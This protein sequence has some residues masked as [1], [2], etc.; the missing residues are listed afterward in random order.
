LLPRSRMT[1]MI[2][3]TPSLISTKIYAPRL[4]PGLVS[5]PHL[6]ERLKAGLHCPLTLISAPAG[7]GK[8][9][10]IAGLA[11]DVD[12]P[13]AWLSLDEGDNDPIRFWAYFIS[14]LQTKLPRAGNT[15]IQTLKSPEVPD[16]QSCLTQLI[17]EIAS[18]E[19][20]FQPYIHILDD[21]HLIEEETI[22]KDLSFLIEH[23]P[24]QLRIVIS[25]RADPPLPLAR[26]RARGQLSEFRAKDLRF[27][28]KE[29]DALL[30]GTMGLGLSDKEVVAVDARTEGWIASL[31]MVGISIQKHENIPGFITAFTGTHRHV[32]DYLTEEVLNRQTADTRSFLLETSILDRVTGPLC[33][34]VTGRQDGQEMMERL[35]SANLF[36]VSL[37][38]E[39]KWYRYH[40][41]FSSMLRSRLQQST[42]ERVNE[43][44]KRAAIWFQ[45][46]GL[47]EEAISQ[48]LAT[49]D[50]ELSS[51]LIEKAAPAALVLAEIG[52][53]LNWLAKLPEATVQR[54]PGLC[55][56]YAFVLT[57]VGRV[58][59]AEAW[60]R[61]IEGLELAG[62]LETLATMT[63]A[64]I[65][66]AYQD[67]KRTMELLA[68]VLEEKESLSNAGTTTEA[69]YSLAAKLGAATILVEAQET[70]GQLRRAIETC[71]LGLSLIRDKALEAPLLSMAGLLHVRFARI[72]CERNDLEGATQHIVAAREIG[73]RSGNRQI[74]ACISIVLG[75]IRQAEGND[76]AALDLMREAEEIAAGSS[77]LPRASNLPWRL[78]FWFA[79][80][81]FSAAARLIQ[82]YE[83][84][85]GIG[86]G[87]PLVALLQ[88]T[89]GITLGHISLCEGKFSKAET[90]LAGVQMEAEQA[91]RMGNVIEILLL[92]ALAVRALGNMAQAID[93]LDRALKL[94]EPEGYVR[95]FVDLGMPMAALL[96]EDVSQGLTSNY[97]RGLLA[98]F[99]KKKN[100]TMKLAYQPLIEPLTDREL[101]VLRLLA[102]GSSNGQIAEKLVLTT[103]TVKTHAHNIYAKLGVRGRVQAI[104]RATSLNLL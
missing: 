69:I 24:R 55:V 14:A 30:N 46:N 16:V 11:N 35:D 64:M 45:Q 65:A 74:Q 20:S 67:D 59:A 90:L 38:N 56:F 98:E 102:D 89:V 78:R 4:R 49:G 77:Q 75:L 31:Q 43:L 100:R 68:Q 5:R 53:L 101:E 61:R 27:T 41:L 88:E 63:Q 6:I 51:E 36:L 52:T 21:Y 86:R 94:A 97:V 92:R 81:D 103:G 83:P 54:H 104:K 26:M 9:T 57:R 76:K 1:T 29:T 25:T 12:L 23:L 87:G 7:Y 73:P 8:T 66:T 70:H 58:N 10:L 95:V 42:P 80:G 40:N 47:M 84:A 33:D 19:P 3:M 32:L 22:H 71:Q 96:R 28:V 99:E 2:V 93:L 34:A 37:D 17:N 62:F 39:R 82:A 60:L 50:F 72:L 18:A 13:V 85:P 79:Q 44:R 15:V 48:A 91:G